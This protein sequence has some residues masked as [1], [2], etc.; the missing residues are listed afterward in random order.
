[1]GVALAQ[2][3]E[4]LAWRPSNQNV[5]RADWSHIPDVSMNDVVA[6]VALI[7]F[8]CVTVV[9][10]G[11]GNVEP[12]PLKRIAEQSSSGEQIYHSRA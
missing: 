8:H 11:Y 9:L 5:A 6:K 10:N 7:G 2:R 3:G 4:A 12:L 1:M